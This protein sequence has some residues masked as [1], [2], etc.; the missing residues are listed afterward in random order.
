MVSKLKRLGSSD[1]IKT[2]PVMVDLL[3]HL[4]NQEQI[5][6]LILPTGG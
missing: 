5:I 1:R 6:H 3:K 4:D 2:E